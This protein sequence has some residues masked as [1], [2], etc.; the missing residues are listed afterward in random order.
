M[1]ILPEKSKGEYCHHSG[2]GIDF[3]QRIQK[4]A[5]TL[6]DKLYF[7]KNQNHIHQKISLRKGNSSHRRRKGIHN[8]YILVMNILRMPERIN[9]QRTQL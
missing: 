1:L 7:R 9:K 6:K 8:A 2:A 3:F 4:K 5:R